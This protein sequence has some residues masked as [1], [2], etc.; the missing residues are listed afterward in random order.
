[1]ATVRKLQHRNQA[2]HADGASGGDREP[3]RRRAATEFESVGPGGGGRDLAA[4]EELQAA[5]SGIA[6]EQETAAADAGFLRLH[7]AEHHLHRDRGIDGAAAP[8]HHFQP[9]LDGQRV[10]CGDHEAVGAAVFGCLRGL[11]DGHRGFSAACGQHAEQQQRRQATGQM[12][13]VR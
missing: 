12:R 6:V 5:A 2:R 3:C 13:G 8:A 7:Q 1:M 10:R 11:E 4:V 9:G